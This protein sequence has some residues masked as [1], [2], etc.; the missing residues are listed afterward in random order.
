MNPDSVL[1]SPGPA[2]DGF[3]FP[4]FRGGLR[5]FLE[6]YAVSGPGFGIQLGGISNSNVGRSTRLHC[7]WPSFGVNVG[8]WTLTGFGLSQL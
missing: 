7:A 4:A 6:V 1:T 5:A 2:G 3:G 8:A